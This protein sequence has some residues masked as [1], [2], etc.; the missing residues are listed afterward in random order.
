MMVKRKGWETPTMDS[1][2]IEPVNFYDF[3]EAL[4]QGHHAPQYELIT[5]YPPAVN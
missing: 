2:N 4:L 5:A 1:A 3:Y